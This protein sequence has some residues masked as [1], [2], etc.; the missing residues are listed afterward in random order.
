MSARAGPSQ[1]TRPGRGT[2]LLGFIVG[3]VHFW[4]RTL[5]GGTLL[6]VIVNT[7][8]G[9]FLVVYTVERVN[10]LC[11]ALLGGSLLE[12]SLLTAG[13]LHILHYWLSDSE[14]QWIGGA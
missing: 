3:G 7:V 9:S 10:L 4:W 12:G 11:G 1:A 5:L 6:G 13:I 14:S 8:G 2:L